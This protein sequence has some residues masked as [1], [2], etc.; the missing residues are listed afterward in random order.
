MPGEANNRR[1]AADGRQPLPISV[2]P[3]G[4]PR[5]GGFNVADLSALYDDCVVEGSQGHLVYRIIAT[6]S[7]SGL[8][9]VYFLDVAVEVSP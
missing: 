4:E 2:E 7:P 6:G 1:L 5:N 9:S 3:S 8:A